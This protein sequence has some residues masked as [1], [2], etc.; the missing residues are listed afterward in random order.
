M[1]SLQLN[2]QIVNP[3]E[4]YKKIKE[5]Y[6]NPHT[7]A[8]TVSKIWKHVKTAL[9]Q[10]DP[11][12]CK[13]LEI[14]KDARA[15]ASKI[16]E[17]NI[18]SD[19]QKKGYVPLVFIEKVR[20]SLKHWS[21]ER[22]LLGMYTHLCPLRNDFHMLRVGVGSGEGNYLVLRPEK[23]LLV[24]QE[25]KT[26]KRYGKMEIPLPPAL[27]SDIHASLSYH[28]RDYLFVQKN[29][30][31]YSSENSFGK[32]ANGHLKKLLQNE[33]VSL[34]MLR[35]IYIMDKAVAAP[36]GERK[37]IAKNM[38]HSVGMQMGYEIEIR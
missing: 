8:T 18:T 26:S 36:A 25:Y 16:Y 1:Q 10:E 4:T 33:W 31:P 29:G 15:G 27:L 19:R 5:T 24:L 30:E 34:T 13:W 17:E 12:R 6:S 20:D 35:H 11:N 14:C 21:I 3:I 7:R 23:P 22:V 37:R 28:P 32:W 9:P 38:G 2:E